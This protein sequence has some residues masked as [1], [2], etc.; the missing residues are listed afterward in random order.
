MKLY[1]VCDLKEHCIIHNTG[2]KNIKIL[3]ELSGILLHMSPSG[4]MLT[5]LIQERLWNSVIL[6]SNVIVY[7][8]LWKI[9]PFVKIQ[10]KTFKIQPYLSCTLLYVTLRDISSLTTIHKKYLKPYLTGM[11]LFC[12]CA[13]LTLSLL[14]AHCADPK[15]S[16]FF[17]WTRR[18]GPHFYSVFRGSY[19]L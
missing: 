6:G 19:N 13:T 16:W 5:L 17:L 7:I 15:K 18:V 3:S 8:T 12:V 9:A 2:G 1:C 10:E 4:A 11:V 14:W